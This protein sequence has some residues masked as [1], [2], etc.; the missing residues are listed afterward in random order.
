MSIS[1]IKEINKKYQIIYVDPP[2]LYNDKRTHKSTGMALSSYPCMKLEDICAL[3]I[4]NISDKNCML[5]LWA[6]LPKLREA[7]EV[8][9]AWGFEYITTGFVWIKQNPKND[10]IYSGIGHWTNANAEL[11]LMGKKGR[12][13]RKAKNIKQI[14]LAH[15]GNHSAKPEEV[16]DR[17]IALMGNL[18]RIEL[19][20]RTKTKGWDVWGNEVKSDINL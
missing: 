8:I 5:F 7:L 6:T 17:I 9:K 19:F 12:L 20:A 10:G 4:K 11:V 18:P 3:P 13:D 15:R 16:K 2:W 1:K 14:V